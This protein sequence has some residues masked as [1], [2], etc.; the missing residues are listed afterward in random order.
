[1]GPVLLAISAA[2]VFVLGYFF[3]WSHGRASGKV[4]ALETELGVDLSVPGDHDD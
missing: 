2:V 4:A 1:M 3:G